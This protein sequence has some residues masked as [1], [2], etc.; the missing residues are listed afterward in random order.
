M[1]AI[2]WLKAATGAALLCERASEINGF[3]NP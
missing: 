2:H 1:G 3:K